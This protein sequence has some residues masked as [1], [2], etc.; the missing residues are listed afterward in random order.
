MSVSHTPSMS[1]DDT[2]AGSEG[3]GVVGWR[4]GLAYGSLGFPLAFVALPLYVLLPHHYASSFGV[5]LAALG[6]VLLAAR[7]LDAVVDP[8]LGRWVDLLFG[9][10]VNAVLGAARWRLSAP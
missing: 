5:P 10:S 7:L 2:R 9:R 8:W 3:R 1:V 4:E 6:G